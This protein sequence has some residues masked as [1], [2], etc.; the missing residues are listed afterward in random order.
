M[1]LVY[2]LCKNCPS[3]SLKSHPP[4]SQQPP[5]KNWAPVKHSLFENL[6]EGS[7]PCPPPPAERGGC[8]LWFYNLKYNQPV[9]TKLTE[10]IILRKYK[11]IWLNT[12]LTTVLKCIIK[13]LNGPH[14]HLV[15]SKNTFL[16]K[17]NHKAVY[18]YKDMASESQSTILETSKNTGGPTQMN[19][20]LFC[21]LTW[22][23]KMKIRC[24]RH[25]DQLCLER[26]GLS[27]CKLFQTSSEPGLNVAGT[28]YWSTT[29]NFSLV[30]L[31]YI[32]PMF[33]S[34]RKHQLTCSE[35]KLTGVYDEEIPF[36]PLSASPTKWSDKLKEFVG[37]LPTNC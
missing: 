2:F 20:Q 15:E 35:N 24:K 10:S 33:P 18:N 23:V 3:P 17:T 25:T 34:S 31:I 12:R 1:I 11:F 26:S 19:L 16:E 4:L 8:T 29:R 14:H 9:S 28:N 7:I 37:K 36:N 27:H 5:S 21:F 6:V 22:F 32:K 13:P 30:P